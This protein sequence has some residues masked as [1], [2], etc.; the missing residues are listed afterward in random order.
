MDKKVF[1]FIHLFSFSTSVFPSLLWHSV[2]LLR[3][4]PL[5]THTPSTNQQRLTRDELTVSWGIAWAALNQS[6]LSLLTLHWS[7][8][9]FLYL[10]SW[11]LIILLWVHLWRIARLHREPVITTANHAIPHTRTHTNQDTRENKKNLKHAWRGK[12]CLLL[13]YSPPTLPL[14]PLHCL[15]AAAGLVPVQGCWCSVLVYVEWGFEHGKKRL[16]LITSLLFIVKCDTVTSSKALLHWLLCLG[17]C[18]P[19]YSSMPDLLL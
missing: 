19:F 8:F 13:L 4:P 5:H 10:I 3:P 1:L 11:Y 15:D 9:F 12:N 7:C 18:L 2:K 14:F 17:S 16:F 6:Q